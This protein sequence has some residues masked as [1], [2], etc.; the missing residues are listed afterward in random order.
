DADAVI[1]GGA[2]GFESRRQKVSEIA[3]HA[4]TDRAN[5]T[6]ARAAA[7]QEFK[8]SGGV[9]D[10]FVF[11]D[12]LVKLDCFLPVVAFVCELDVALDSPEEIGAESDEAV[13]GVPVGDAAH[14]GVDA[15][16]F[17]EHDDAWAIAAWGHG[18]IGVEF[19]AVKRFD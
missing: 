9:F 1:S 6:A 10:G 19:S 12:L 17:L 15:E 7:T 14:V 11:V 2:I 18:E 3:A 16:D 4:E 8:R 13:R 5:P